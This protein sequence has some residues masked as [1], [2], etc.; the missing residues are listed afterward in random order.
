M[1]AFLNIKDKEYEA[2][3]TFAFAKR[4]K[5]E[6][7]TKENN[8]S[9]S[10]IFMGLIQNDEEALV[11]FWDCGTAYIPRR[12]F[13]REDIEKAIEARIEEEGD[14]INLFK[15]AM[16]VLDDSAFFKRKAARLKN[17]LTILNTTGK[18]DQE[19][20]ENKKAYEFIKESMA[21]LGIKT[22]KKEK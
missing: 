1:T 2:K 13:K 4:A 19:K 11:K 21:E 18:T 3:G 7:P 10:D 16:S 6:Y 22:K 12:D 9:F 8:D 20:E 15:E 17:G 14:T 5:Q